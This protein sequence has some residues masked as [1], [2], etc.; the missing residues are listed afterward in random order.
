MEASWK[1]LQEARATELEQK[2]LSEDARREL[3]LK[4]KAA[5]ENFKARARR[6]LASSPCAPAARHG[7]C[8]RRRK[9]LGSG[10]P[11]QRAAVLL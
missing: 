2:A 7:T 10:G 9:L 1:E 4:W 3:E 5:Q 8:M 11:V 6:R